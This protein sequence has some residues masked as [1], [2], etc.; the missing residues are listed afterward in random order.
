MELIHDREELQHFFEHHIQL[1]LYSLGDLDDPFWK[2][3]IWFGLR[4]AGQ[5]K[6]VA[7]LYTG[8]STPTLLALTHDKTAMSTLLKL[9]LHL[10][11]QNVYCHLSAGLETAFSQSYAIQSYGE[12][13]KMGLLTPE[14]LSQFDTSNTVRLTRD[15]LTAVTDF[16]AASY[17]DNWFEPHMLD[18]GY[19]FGIRKNGVLVSVAGLHLFSKKY[20]V[21]ALGGITT[22]PR[23]RGRGLATAVTVRLCQQLRDEVAHIGLNV[24]ANN[25]A[26]VSLYRKLGFQEMATYGEFMLIRK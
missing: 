16:Y 12:H 15:D 20:G 3:T 4:K 21:A 9:C 18:I 1:H 24:L 6:E 25:L 13:L 7:L 10:L 23:C 26:A 5:L 22:H 2:N 8:L 11:P 14:K 17:P 19:T